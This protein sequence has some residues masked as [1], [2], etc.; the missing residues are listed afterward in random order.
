LFHHFWSNIT[1][2]IHFTSF[3]NQFLKSFS[4]ILK[5]HRP[6]TARC[7]RCSAPRGA[8][9]WDPQV[10]RPCWPVT[11][12]QGTVLDRLDLTGG[13]VAGGVVGTVELHKTMCTRWYYVQGQR[14]IGARWLVAMACG[15]A[16]WRRRG[17]VPVHGWPE[18]RHRLATEL[19]HCEAGTVCAKRGREGGGAGLATAACAAVELRRATARRK[20]A[21]LGLTSGRIAW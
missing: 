2:D 14:T 8:V 1:G 17:L 3:V 15:G 10:N 4:L 5:F 6:K 11:R 9:R 16:A 12:R 18:R 7:T 20:N 13:E 21:R 19:H